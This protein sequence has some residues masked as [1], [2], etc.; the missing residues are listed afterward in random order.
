MVMVA[1]FA[2]RLNLETRTISP[3]L[4][5]VRDTV[6]FFYLTVIFAGNIS[7]PL[8][9]RT[10]PQVDLSTAG[11]GS[12]IWEMIVVLFLCIGLGLQSQGSWKKVVNA[13]QPFWPLVIWI[14]LSIAWSDFP[15]ITLRRSVR[16]FM[17]VTS[18]ICFA[19]AYPDQYRLL[20]VVFLSFGLILLLDIALIAIPDASFTPIGYAGIH[21]NKNQAGVFCFLALPVFLSA[22]FNTRIFPGRTIALILSGLCLTILVLS[23]SKTA[24][25][26]TPVCLLM[27]FGLLALRR[28]PPVTMIIAV[29]ISGLGAAIA[30]MLITSVG[31]SEFLA[32]T[33]ED[34]TLTHRD[35]I[36]QYAIFRFWQTP[37]IG[38]GYGAVW[39]V[40]PD[41]FSRPREFGASI[42]V[43]QAHNGYID[44]LVQLGFVGLTLTILFMLEMSFR[45]IRI[46]NQT[47]STAPITFIAIYTAVGILLYNMV[48]SSLLRTGSEPWL[49]YVLLVSNALMTSNGASSVLR[50]NVSSGS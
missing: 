48:E 9:P 41:S 21:D 44:I 36:W 33:L 35:Q 47:V 11:Q 46:S 10:L 5:M 45:L 24:W 8:Q 1:M 17:E 42:D 7:A 20:R 15:E 4:A 40:D 50:G 2:G 26:L 25:G 43:G 18:L 14:L 23:L 22:F 34:P 29:V 12:F 31:F 30:F 27:A 32:I 49:Y 39:G 13:L 19:A 38:H 6:L 28:L 3:A 37:F 16:F